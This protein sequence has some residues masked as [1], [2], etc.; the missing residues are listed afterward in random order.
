MLNTV[1][2]S[3]TGISRVQ[4]FCVV[5][6]LSELSIRYLALSVPKCLD[7]LTRRSWRHDAHGETL[8]YEHGQD[9]RRGRVLLGSALLEAAG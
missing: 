6:I 2:H 7:W 5:F 8:G 4:R 3:H 1:R 9:Q